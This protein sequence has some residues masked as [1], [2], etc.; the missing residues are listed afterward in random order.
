LGY[1]ACELTPVVIVSHSA[2]AFFRVE[3]P[4]VQRS[5]AVAAAWLAANSQQMSQRIARLGA[6]ALAAPLS[7]G[8]DATTATR[9]AWMGLRGMSADRLEVLGE[10][11][12]E[13]H[14]RDHIRP[15]GRDLLARARR[16]KLEIVLVSDHLDCIVRPLAASLNVSMVVANRMELRNHKAT[17]RLED[18][19]VGRL[20]GTWLRNFAQQHDID[21]QRSCAYGAHDTDVPLLSSVGLP[22]AVHPDRGL[23]AAARDLDWPVVE[24]T[25]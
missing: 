9:M 11:Y 6:V 24:A 25:G 3:G 23:R 17:G 10:E 19:V 22:C 12:F 15:V 20:G 21:L 13:T 5:A 7:L 16:E 18:P 14:L 2:A 1:L 8:R 4:L